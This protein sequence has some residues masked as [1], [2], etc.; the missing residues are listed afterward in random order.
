MSEDARSKSLT[1]T[2]DKRYQAETTKS[3]F[4][5]NDE[6]S[7]SLY[8]QWRINPHISVQ[9]QQ[10]IENTSFRSTYNHLFK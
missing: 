1:K 2:Y 8:E 10:K 3:N 6:E 5:R 4:Y 9:T 7:S